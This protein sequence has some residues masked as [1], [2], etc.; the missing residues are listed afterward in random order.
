MGALITRFAPSP[1]GFLHLGHAASAL[2]ARGYARAAGGQF[3]LRLED[4]DA[5]RC[6]AEF[7]AAIIE[8]LSW[9]GLDWDG[10]VRVQSAHVQDYRDCLARLQAMGVIYPCFCSRRDSAAAVGAPQGDA[11]PP[12]PGRC[13]TLGAEDVAARMAAGRAFA[14]RLD[15]ARARAMVDRRLGW[16]EVGVGWAEA[17][18]ERLGDVVL[19]RKDAPV[20]YFLAATHDDAVQQVNLVVRGEDLRAATAVQVLLQALLGWPRP[21]YRHHALMRDGAGRRLAKRDGDVALRDWRAAGYL[22]SDVRKRLPEW[23]S[24]VTLA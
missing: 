22:P 20:S 3:L 7:A 24:M 2:L 9:L 5:G 6:R 16:H 14:W 21:D 18:P 17:A 10:P 4:I 1:T 8:D 13:R 11:P 23:H 19:G 15:Q 12:Y